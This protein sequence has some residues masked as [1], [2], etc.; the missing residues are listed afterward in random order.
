M[1]KSQSGSKEKASSPR[2]LRLNENVRHAISTIIA[3]GDV[4]DPDLAGVSIT[5]SEVRVS[6]DMRNAV[7]YVMP[8][9]GVDQDK[10]VTALNKAGPYLRGQ[11]AKRVKMKYLPKLDFR[12]D[13]SYDEASSIE[14]L[15]ADPKVMRDVAHIDDDEE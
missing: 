5:V 15:L 12:I 4:H 14:K 7:V 3:R 10:T 6:T 8:L 1:G 2:A 9:G 13:I 11:L